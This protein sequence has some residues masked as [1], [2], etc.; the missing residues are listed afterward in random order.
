MRLPSLAAGLL[1]GLSAQAAELTL[2][3]V[4]VAPD[5]YAVIGHLGNQTYENEG[6][7]NNLGFVVTEAAV[8]DQH[9][10]RC[11]VGC[12]RRRSD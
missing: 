4:T 12:W 8:L 10:G 7:N 3:P 6:L 1:L 9:P 11:R 2:N 5:V